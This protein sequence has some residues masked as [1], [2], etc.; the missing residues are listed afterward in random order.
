MA[1]TVNFV[2]GF[3]V[4]IVSVVFVFHSAGVHACKAGVYHLSHTSSSFCSG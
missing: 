4:V 1:E 3:F 2:K